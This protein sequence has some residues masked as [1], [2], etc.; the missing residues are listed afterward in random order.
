MGSFS[1]DIYGKKEVKPVENASIIPAPVPAARAGREVSSILGS[2]PFG[3]DIILSGEQ[4]KRLLYL[5]G[6]SRA[7]KNNNASPFNSSAY[8]K[9]DGVCV[10]DPHGV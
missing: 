8:R 1:S 6:V 9:N 10:L 5:L 7:W 2:D 3:N 4:R